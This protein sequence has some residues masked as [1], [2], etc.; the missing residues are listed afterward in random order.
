MSVQ[1]IIK[2][3]AIYTTTLFKAFLAWFSDWRLHIKRVEFWLTFAAYAIPLAFLLYV[4]YWNFLPFGY[5]KTFT[6]DVGTEGDTSSEFYLE[7][8]RNLSERKV[9]PDG[10]TFRELNGSAYAIFKPKAVFKD[11]AITVTVEGDD[12]EIIPP[13]IQFKLD[14]HKWDYLW[15]F[16]QGKTLRDLGL[17][18]NAYTFDACMYFDGNSRAELPNSSAQFEDKA[19]VVYAEW[20]PRDVENDNQQIV[21]H[22]NWEIFQNRKSIVLRTGRMNDKD[23]QFLDITYQIDPETFFFKKH[24]L[25]MRYNPAQG[26][27]QNGYIE[28]FV[29]NAL[30][31]RTYIGQQKIYSEYGGDERNLS[32]GKSYHNYERYRG[33]NG[34][35]CNLRIKDGAPQATPYIAA[36]ISTP[37]KY[38]IITKKPTMI[39][40]I[41]LN[42]D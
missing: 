18:G 12:I 25:L 20:E 31:E 10:A 7:P 28:L 19:F 29:D 16:T 1:K 40:K 4:L 33:F 41:T 3:I 2:N 22:F 27:D 34:S 32:I 21:G 37:A 42:V 38:I 36:T 11:A 8:S 26:A 17:I 15:D 5:N 13:V 6:I 14:N 9:S 24:Q 39:Q 23:G 30:A 35:I